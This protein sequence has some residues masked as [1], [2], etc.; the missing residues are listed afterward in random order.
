MREACEVVNQYWFQILERTVMQV[1][2]AVKNEA[3][4][5]VSVHEE[6]RLVATQDGRFVSG[7]MVKEIWEMTL[8]GWLAKKQMKHSQTSG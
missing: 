8:E 3:S 5:K 7:E 1:P 2:K 4:R 6:M